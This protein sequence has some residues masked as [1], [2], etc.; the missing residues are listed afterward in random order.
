MYRITAPRA[1]PDPAPRAVSLHAHMAL[2]GLALV[3][4]ALLSWYVHVLQVQVLRA[5][6]FRAE[7][8][9]SGTMVAKAKSPV[10]R[11]QVIASRR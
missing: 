5:Q 6:Q 7:L 3:V 11:Q 1:G 9:L 10:R 8:Q 2:A 4:I